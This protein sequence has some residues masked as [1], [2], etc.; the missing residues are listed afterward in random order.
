LDDMSAKIGDMLSKPENIEM[1][2]NIMAMFGNSGGMPGTAAGFSAQGQNPQA[3]GPQSQGQQ[4]QSQQEQGGQ[5][6]QQGGFGGLPFD[7]ETM[8]KMKKALDAV[9]KD[10]PRVELLLA[11]RPNLSDNRQ[12]KVDEAISLMRLINLIPLLQEGA[13]GKF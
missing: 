4:N 13:F 12:H 8:M 10:D 7:A 2:K 6:G 11:L 5:Q 3:P 1:I 9:R